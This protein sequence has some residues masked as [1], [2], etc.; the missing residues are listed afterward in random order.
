LS[1]LRIEVV[2]FVQELKQF[3]TLRVEVGSAAFKALDRMRDESG[4]R[5]RKIQ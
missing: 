1:S 3:P 2:D 5:A 4:M